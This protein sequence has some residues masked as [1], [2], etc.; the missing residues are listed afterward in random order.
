MFEFDVAT[1]ANYGEEIIEMVREFMEVFGQ[2]P[3]AE[4]QVAL[5]AEES[6]ELLEAAVI[7]EMNPNMETMVAFIKEAA[8]WLYVSGGLIVAL[9]DAGDEMP[10]VPAHITQGIDI[11]GQ[12]LMAAMDY[13]LPEDVLFEAVEEVHESNMSKLDDYGDPIFREDGKILKGPYYEEP[14]LGELA[15]VC[16]DLFMARR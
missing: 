4:L 12:M 5:I 14:Y 2:V 16:L 3:D 9:D 10:Q 11:A 8:D 13:F 15:E 6:A 1:E 7:L